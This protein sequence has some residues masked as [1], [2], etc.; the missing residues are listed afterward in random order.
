V[1]Q[2]EFERR[3]AADWEQLE[4]WLQ[5][6]RLR[7]AARRAL[8]QRLAEDEA[9]L[10][11]LSEV[12]ARYRQLCAHLSL[13][14]ERRYAPSLVGRLEALV[15]AG[16]AALYGA[17]PGGG[18]RLT[19][20]IAVGFPRLVRQQWRCVGLGVALFFL[21]LLGLI[22]AIQFH[23]DLAGVILAPSTLAE[24]EAMYSPSNQKLGQRDA[25]S[26]VSMFGFYVFNNV[27]IGFQTFAG[28]ILFG[29]GSLFFLLFNGVYLG[30]FIG[31]LGAVGLGEQVGSFVAGHSAL[32]L[33]AIA[34]A[35][36]A[37]LKLGAA[38]LAPGLRSRRRAL[39]EDGRVAL[40]LAAGAGL[41]FL[42]AAAVEAFWSPLVLA[43]PWPK[44][45]VG[46]AGWLLLA[47]YLFGAGRRA[48]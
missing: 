15:Q 21:P 41:M 47:A 32:E 23:P 48:G 16:H 29:L 24:A 12:P 43:D 37:G 28:G 26:S 17:R 9:A 7:P 13:A 46:V 42:A 20:F 38:L 31:H 5:R 34:I 40:G 6:R 35:G 3:H 36:G 44:Y 4:R 1:R 8:Q 11:P 30:T 19:R 22:A 27:R 39:V 18:M 25:S 14:R 45:V 33:V 10:L 2:A